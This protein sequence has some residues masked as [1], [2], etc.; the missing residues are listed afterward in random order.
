MNV[1]NGFKRTISL[2][3]ALIGA[4]FLGLG[5]PMSIGYGLGLLVPHSGYGGNPGG[6]VVF[7]GVAGFL[8]I[9]AVPFFGIVTY[10]ISSTLIS[11]FLQNKHIN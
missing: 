3:L 8:T 2:I 5:V 9:F 7:V 4:Y 6:F 11:K 1:S 10:L